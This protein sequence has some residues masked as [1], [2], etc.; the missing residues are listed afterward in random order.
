MR[1]EPLAS[2]VIVK[3]TESDERTSGG[4]VLPDVAREKPRQGRVLSVGTGRRLKNGIRVPLQVKEGDRVVFTAWAGMPV[5]V[6]D[7]ELL[8]LDEEEILA[9]LE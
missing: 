2:K 6:A 7:D 3:R 4:I 9:I 8:I 5:R 1:L